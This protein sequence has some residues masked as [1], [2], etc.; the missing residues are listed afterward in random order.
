MNEPPT[1]TAI[2]D[3]AVAVSLR[4]AL[5]RMSAGAVLVSQAVAERVGV[6][7][8]DLEALDLLVMNGPMTAGQLAELTGLTTGAVTG[9][10]DRLERLGYA[11]READ[12]SDRRRV[13]VRAV[14]EAIARD[15]E[16]AYA[17]LS[18]AIDRLLAEYDETDL[19]LVLDFLTRAMA[20]GNE[21]IARLRAGGAVKG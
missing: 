16:P 21:E 13:I 6:R 9:L 12:P 11:R 15:L 2:H 18:E 19:E 8:A 17:G 10:V 7:S 14:E 5:R 3:R 20:A 4:H 1:S